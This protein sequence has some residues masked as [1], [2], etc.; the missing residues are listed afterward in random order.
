VGTTHLPRHRCPAPAEPA[1]AA[2]PA[3]S[4][5]ESSAPPDTAA[6]AGPDAP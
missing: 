4:S 6:P 5:A 1:P 3:E 2:A